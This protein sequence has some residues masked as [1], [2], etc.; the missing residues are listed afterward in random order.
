MKS[1]LYCFFFK[2]FPNL[3]FIWF[4]TTPTAPCRQCQEGPFFNLNTWCCQLVRTLTVAGESGNGR[5]GLNPSVAGSSPPEMSSGSPAPGPGGEAGY[6]WRSEENHRSSLV[7]LILVVLV[8]VALVIVILIMVVL[9][10]VVLIMMVVFI[11]A[12]L[13]MVVLVMVVIVM[14]VLVIV[15]LVMDVLVMVVFIVVVV[16][17]FFCSKWRGIFVPALQ[18]VLT[19]VFNIFLSL[20]CISLIYFYFINLYKKLFI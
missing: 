5:C 10:M 17:I 16:F 18:K 9:I 20:I 1:I 13:V 7:I 6:D 15:V 2:T 19:Q 11:M 3:W 12:V 14:T 8:M 4:K